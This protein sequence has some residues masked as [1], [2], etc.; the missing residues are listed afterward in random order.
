MSDD[1]DALV[2]YTPTTAQERVH[3]RKVKSAER[4]VDYECTKQTIGSLIY[5]I[6]VTDGTKLKFPKSFRIL[7][8]L[9]DT[10]YPID[11][12]EPNKIAGIIDIGVKQNP[13]SAYFQSIGQS[14][15]VQLELVLNKGSTTDSVS[16]VA[17]FDGPYTHRMKLISAMKLA[18]HNH[19]KQ[20]E[21]RAETCLFGDVF[22]QKNEE[23]GVVPKR[24]TKNQFHQWIFCEEDTEFKDVWVNYYKKKAEQ[25]KIVCPRCNPELVNQVSDDGWTTV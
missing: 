11:E 10:K 14:D 18:V 23:L 7:K 3:F 15:T 4:D 17:C 6:G 2:S 19:P 1:E 20:P 16:W 24:F 8:T 21:E 13:L 9:L 25:R 5:T 12:T 22:I